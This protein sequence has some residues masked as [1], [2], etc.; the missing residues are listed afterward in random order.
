MIL[1][2]NLIVFERLI[3]LL[4]PQRISLRTTEITSEA[5]ICS[6][7]SYGATSED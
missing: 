1:A 5:V 3:Y 2:V 6:S 7:T 4:V